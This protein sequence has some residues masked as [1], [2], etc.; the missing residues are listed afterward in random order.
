MGCNCGSNKRTVM[1]QVKTANGN[2]VQFVTVA[3]AQ[4][5]C[6]GCP[7]KAVTA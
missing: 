4:K 1:Y 6:P 2:L 3:E 5:A 7:I